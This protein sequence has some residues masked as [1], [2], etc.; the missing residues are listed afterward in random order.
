[1]TAADR[2]QRL[3]NLEERGGWLKQTEQPSAQARPAGLPPK[4][5]MVQG[6]DQGASQNAGH[7]AGQDPAAS[8]GQTGD[9]GG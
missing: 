3:E 6:A 5:G 8:A 7:G 4:P 2:N 1:M 9:S